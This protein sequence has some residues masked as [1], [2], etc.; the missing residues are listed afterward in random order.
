V[1]SLGYCDRIR[2]IF[3]P[4]SERASPADFRSGTTDR[5]IGGREDVSKASKESM[6]GVVTGG[7]DL[8]WDGHDLR[9]KCLPL[10]CPGR[11][12]KFALTSFQLCASGP[13][14]ETKG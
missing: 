9:R 6:L 4:H 11:V 3:T 14:N 5:T 8:H 13:G 10:S 7:R 12:A 2:L 1:V